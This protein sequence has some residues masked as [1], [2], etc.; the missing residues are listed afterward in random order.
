MPTSIPFPYPGTAI[1]LGAQ[2]N[3]AGSLAFQR[4][5]HQT[6]YIG[7]SS[8]AGVL[9]YLEVALAYLRKLLGAEKVEAVGVDLHPGYSTRRLVERLAEEWSGS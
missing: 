7:D 2:E 4:R 5:L 6:Q 1:G 3:I 9:E 8:S